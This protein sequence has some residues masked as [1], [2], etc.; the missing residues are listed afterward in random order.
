MKKLLILFVCINIFILPAFGIIED[1][2]V[3]MTLDKN[4]K[5]EKHSYENIEDTFAENN[6]NKNFSDLELAA[7]LL[8]KMREN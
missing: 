1:D 2:F 8:K 3:E 5:I 6:K 7:A 4:L